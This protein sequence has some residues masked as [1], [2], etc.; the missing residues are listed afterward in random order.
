MAVA[1]E[2]WI[3]GPF[4]VDAVRG[5][6][7]P[8]QR[9]VLAV[10]HHLTAGTRLAEVLPLL[11]SDRRVQV[12]YTAAPSSPFTAGLTDYLHGLGGLVVP[13]SQATRTSFDLAIAASHGMLEE[14]HAPILTLPHGSGPGKLYG[15]IQGDGPPVARPVTGVL[16]ERLVVGGRVVPSVVVLPHERHRELLARDCPE[17]LPVAVVAGDPCLDRLVG[18]RWR[19]DAYRHAFGARPGRRLVLVSSTWGPTS[20][21]GRHPDVLFQV[22][23]Q[24]P[25][26]RY[27]VV[28]ALHPH[29]WTYSGRR[30]VTRWHSDCTRFGVRLLPPEEGWR[31]ALIAADLVLGDH[32][33]V[34]YY[35][36]AL[37]VPV[38]L[39][40]FAEQDVAPGSHIARLGAIAPRLDWD[41]P[42]RPQLDAAALAFDAEVYASLRCDLSSRPG[43]AAEILRREMY[44]LMR[45]PE[46]ECPARLEPVPLPC[47]VQRGRWAA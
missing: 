23:A 6:T 43:R 36:A 46:P 30:Q 11:E 3:R 27:T 12:V 2:D 33:S 25:R 37:G 35:G 13:W 29:I 4:G 24:L 17:A 42:V 15:R 32:G 1:C 39:G 41:G 20:L 8:D 38:L 18:C 34:T 14:L 7:V 19:R 44:R 31:A 21:F 9:T 40:E 45:L 26:D 28:A 22:A 16:R 47:P 10:V 5:T